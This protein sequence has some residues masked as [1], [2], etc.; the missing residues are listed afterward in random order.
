MRIF[1]PT[2][3]HPPRLRTHRLLEGFDYYVVCHTQEDAERYQKETGVEDSRI[4]VSGA[5]RKI[6]A[7]HYWIEDQVGPDEWFWR[8]DDNIQRFDAVVAGENREIRGDELK[9]RMEIMVEEADLMGANLAGMATTGNLFFR[10]K[11]VSDVGYILGKAA[12]RRRKDIRMNPRYNPMDD[13][14]L[15]A[16]YLKRDGLVYRDNHIYAVAKHYEK[17]GIG[18]YQERVNAKIRAA[19]NLMSDF[20]GM[21]RNKKKANCDARAE[22]QVK[23]IDRKAVA[24]WR[25]RNP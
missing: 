8:M 23:L 22:L 25:A 2:T 4:L 10:K 9:R 15:T 1:I 5:E 6:W 14:G 20:P 19:E 13:Y 24:E 18:T 7:Q 21:F 12:A 11:R 16:E 17:G 3:A